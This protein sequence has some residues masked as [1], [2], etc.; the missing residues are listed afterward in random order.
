[1][2]LIHFFVY[3]KSNGTKTK[4]LFET[5]ENVQLFC[6]GGCYLSVV[7]LSVHI[8]LSLSDVTGQV[9]NRMGDV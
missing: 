2:K 3:W 1:M 6:G 5:W 9:R 7:K 4:V 8:D